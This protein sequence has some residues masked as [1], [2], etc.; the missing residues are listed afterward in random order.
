MLLHNAG[1]SHHLH[2][3]RPAALGLLDR[4]R[5]AAHSASIANAIDRPA[6]A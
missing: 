4:L 3:L 2:G 5:A 6:I 1:A